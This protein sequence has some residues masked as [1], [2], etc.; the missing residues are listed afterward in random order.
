MLKRQ[1]HSPEWTLY[2]PLSLHCS[3]LET[4]FR[5]PIQKPSHPEASVHLPHSSCKGPPVQSPTWICLSAIHLISN[6]NYMYD[7]KPRRLPSP[8]S[9]AE[10]SLRAD[11]QGEAHKFP[12]ENKQQF[13]SLCF[14]FS[15]PL[16][17]R[18]RKL[19]FKEHPV[20]VKSILRCQRQPPRHC[21]KPL[22]PRN[23]LSLG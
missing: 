11:D 16:T 8:P 19:S 9:P 17:I 1:T 21:Q 15:L 5:P 4:D 23:G 6:S 7:Q 12:T 18:D 10:M 3:S 13:L 20:Q 2:R 22:P 14:G